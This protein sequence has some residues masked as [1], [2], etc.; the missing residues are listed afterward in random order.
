[1]Y[2]T[3]YSSGSRLVLLG[4]NPFMFRGLVVRLHVKRTVAT[5][6]FFNVALMNTCLEQGSC[7]SSTQRVVRSESNSKS[8]TAMIR[9]RDNVLVAKK[10]DVVGC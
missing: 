9:S 8:G 6:L 2:W 7:V 5:E 3:T 1:M 10:I 4:I